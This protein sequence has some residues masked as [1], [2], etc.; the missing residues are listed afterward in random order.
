MRIAFTNSSNRKVAGAESYIEAVGTVL[1]DSG[2]ELALWHEVERPEE[3][4]LL[5]RELFPEQHSLE[6]LALGQWLRNLEKWKPD[7]I[8]GHALYDPTPEGETLK[9]APSLFF[10][11]NYHGTCVS[12]QKCHS[13]PVIE[14]CSR[15]FGPGCLAAFYPRRC[16]GLN[17]LTLIGDYR[18]TSARLEVI[19]SY[20]RV[21]THTTHMAEEYR[22]HGVPCDAI[23]GFASARTAPVSMGA[24]F[25]ANER[26]LVFIGRM[27]ALKGGGV[28]LDALP[29]I[30]QRLP[31]KIRVRFVGDGPARDAWQKQAA[32]ITARDPRITVDFPGWLSGDQFENA[33]SD[34]HLHILPSLW[35]EPFGMSGLELGL[36]G[37]PT[38]AFEIGGIP[39]WLTNGVNG[40]LAPYTQPLAPKLAA[41][42]GRALDNERTYTELRAGAR[43]VAASLSLEK[44]CA[45]L[46]EVFAELHPGV[47]AGACCL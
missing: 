24:T 40:V 43:R 44:H 31:G 47:T 27:T 17:P 1:K 23:S 28:L 3:R 42:V 26:T 35:P 10:A 33:I 2:H 5:S 19:R 46:L 4:A 32:Q 15:T 45:R 20:T 9:I 12:G 18:R 6:K 16:G 8:F 7:L 39:D 41:A 13:N 34:A 29:L 21:I 25:L 14:A 36:K 37:I 11:H 38:A 30:S 22:K